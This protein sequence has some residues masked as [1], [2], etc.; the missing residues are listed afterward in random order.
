MANK[1]ALSSAAFC[2]T[3]FATL[4]LP[5][6]SMSSVCRAVLQV[7]SAQPLGEAQ[8]LQKVMKVTQTG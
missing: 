4:L 5:V 2:C 6:R 3:P 1:E 7:C 8:G